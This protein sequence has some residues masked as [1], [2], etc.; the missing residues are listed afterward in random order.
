MVCEECLYKLDALYDFREKSVKTEYILNSM[1]KGL[2]AT[3]PCN[4]QFSPPHSH[5]LEDLMCASNIHPADALHS[6]DAI[7][8]ADT[9]HSADAIH[10]RS[11]VNNVH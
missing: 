5:S 9:I 11:Q 2:Y 6:T 7:H 1:M 3:L 4:Q 10:L 8:S